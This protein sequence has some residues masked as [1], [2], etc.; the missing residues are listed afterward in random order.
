MSGERKPPR[1]ALAGDDHAHPLET[2]VLWVLAASLAAAM[3]LWLTGELAGRLFEG[4]WPRTHLSDMAGVLVRFRAHAGDP[5]AAW[6]TAEQK[7]I[8]GPFAFYAMLAALLGPVAAAALL[9]LRHRVRP[10]AKT[11]AGAR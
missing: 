8:P 2:A 3:L 7:A 10:A 9:V 5:A 11:G 6:P 1:F 4:T